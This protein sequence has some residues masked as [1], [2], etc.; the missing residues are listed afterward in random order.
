[1]S[2]TDSFNRKPKTEN[3]KPPYFSRAQLGVILLLGAALL[4][5]WGWRGNFGR[6]PASPPAI[7]YN[8]VFVEAAGA[9]INPGVFEF[10]A[11]PSPA[12]VWQRAGGPG[13]APEKDEKLVSGSRVDISPDGSYK[14]SRMAGSRLMT[15]GLAIDIN[16]ATPEDLE[17]LPGIGPV[18]AGR[19]VDFRQKHGPFKQVADLERVSGIGPKKLAQLKPY[20]EIKPQINAD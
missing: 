6:P 16:T 1:M 4:F 17:A 2:N 14:M 7:S 10:P 11:P 3:R 12:Q 15:L 20:V 13:A 9:V 5:L 8:P 18:L 19:I